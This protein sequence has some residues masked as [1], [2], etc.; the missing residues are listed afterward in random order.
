MKKLFLLVLMVLTIT[1][2]LVIPAQA[3]SSLFP[4]PNIYQWTKVFD[5]LNRPV[6]LVSANDNSGRLFIIE[7]DGV[8]RVVKNGQLQTTPFLD[9][10]DRVGA[11]GSEQG[12]L[13]LAFDPRYTRNGRFYVNYTN[14]AGNTVIARYRVS[15]QNPDFTAPSSERVLLRV[16]QPYANH[17]GGKI[18]F[19]PDRYLYIALGDGGSGGDPLGKGQSL[20][21]LLGKI[22]RIDVSKST[23]F[24]VPASNPFR[25]AGQRREIWAY[26]LRNP[27]RFSFDS[28]T[29]EM[30]IADV[31]QGQYEEVD[32][33]AAKK[34]GV[35]FGW[36]YREGMHP[37]Q[38]TPP[39]NVKLVDPVWEY[40]HSQGCSI[41]GG[42]VYRGNALPELQGI[43]LAGDFCKGSVW[44]LKRDD[45]GVWQSQLLWS[46]NFLIS[47]FGVDQTGEIYL[48]DLKGQ[49]YKL[50]RKSA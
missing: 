38:G 29:G 41:T 17:N 40:D 9:I 23:T 33:L 24:V 2:N 19:G 42:Y 11:Q 5:G 30:Y 10:R 35:N 48:L 18:A 3:Q 13:G 50:E 49:V 46:S 26:G 1:T 45:Q 7:Q 47:S 27:W 44:G 15:R 25:K 21:T 36:N 43:Y 37:Y 22:L 34:G 12:L 6:E 16:K 39:A 14:K 32:V 31:G 4:D 8:I 20:R 28:L